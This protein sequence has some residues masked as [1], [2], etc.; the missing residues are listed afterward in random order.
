MPGKI[1][2][3]DDLIAHFNMEFVAILAFECSQDAIAWLNVKK[4]WPSFPCVS[5]G[6]ALMRAWTQNFAGNPKLEPKVLTKVV[7]M[8]VWRRFGEEAGRSQS[9]HC[10]K[11][12]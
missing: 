11:P 1:V 6:L 10:A 5:P 9:M 12:H 8:A 3:M 2:H 7:T 4:S